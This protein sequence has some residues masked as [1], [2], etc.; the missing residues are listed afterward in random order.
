MVVDL[1][2]RQKRLGKSIAYGKAGS[3]K[4]KFKRYDVWGFFSFFLRK[5]GI[6]KAKGQE[7]QDFCSDQVVD[8][9][10]EMDSPPFMVLD[11]EKTSPCDLFMH[12]KGNFSAKLYYLEV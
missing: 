2:M 1:T 9:F 12:L 4:N 6:K 8:I 5:I 11:S 10:Q 3:K 7:S